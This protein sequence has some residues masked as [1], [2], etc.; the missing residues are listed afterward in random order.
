MTLETQYRDFN[1]IDPASYSS[2]DLIP[3]GTIANAT[4]KIREGNYGENDYLIKNERTGSI[5]IKVEFT[6]SSGDHRGRK[7][8][9]LI[10]I[11]GI[12]KDEPGNDKWGAMG[13]KLIRA[14]LESAHNL[15]PTDTSER[16]AAIR[17]LSSFGKLN[18]L[19]CLIKVGIEEDKTG[20]YEDRNKIV[21]VI[22]NNQKEYAQFR[23]EM[24]QG[25][26][27]PKD[28]RNH[29]LDDESE[30]EDSLNDEIPF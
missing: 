5:G 1:N 10:G 16:A 2:Y 7:I 8:F 18:D 27:K 19:N 22:T 29:P 15:E 24:S 14:I 12:K 9:Q 6:V 11:E 13:R 25:E 17:N 21:A 30:L 4:I 20:Q 26:E 3:A 23:T 28:I